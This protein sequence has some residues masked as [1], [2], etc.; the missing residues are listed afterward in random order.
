M[1]IFSILICVQILRE[2]VLMKSALLSCK[3]N[4]KEWER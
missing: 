3:G 2:N 1:Q 4:K